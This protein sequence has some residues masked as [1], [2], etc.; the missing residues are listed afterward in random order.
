MK[1]FNIITLLIV[2]S[3]FMSVSCKSDDYVEPV[4][5]TKNF[6][7]Y[8][9]FFNTT[10]GS[11]LNPTYAQTS[12]LIGI[13]DLSQGTLS[14]EWSFWHGEDNSGELEWVKM[15]SGITFIAENS[16]LGY[17]VI[18]DYAQY[19]DSSIAPT[20]DLASLSFVFDKGGR[21]KLKIRNT[22]DKQVRYF[23]SIT[24]PVDDVTIVN[25]YVDAVSIGNGEY[26]LVREYEFMVFDRFKPS[27][28][29]YYDPECT[30]PIDLTPT[31]TF[32]DM[33]VAEVTIK[34]GETLTFAD[35]TGVDENGISTIYS[36]PSA[37]TWTWDY[38]E[39]SSSLDHTPEVTPAP[40]Y[41][42]YQD[43]IF[44]EVGTYTV[45]LFVVRN[46]P[47]YYVTKFYPTVNTTEVLPIIVHVVDAADDPSVNPL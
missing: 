32:D 13:K 29:A 1:R 23:Y 41:G 35:T 21:Y 9:S 12:E 22:Y 40:A 39:G 42:K 31:T 17:S 30:E 24:D 26:E 46:A 19:V 36:L 6:G 45:K 37:R 8:A 20:N 10:S 5:R 47:D 15:D 25:E 27:F 38:V 43:F 33:E 4:S 44:D 16:P 3:L 28:V 18:D 11:N 7:L 34:A 2:G 14:H